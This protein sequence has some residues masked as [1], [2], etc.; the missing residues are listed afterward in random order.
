L[1]C[2]A[3][4]FFRRASARVFGIRTAREHRVFRTTIDCEGCGLVECLERGNECI[5][6]I[7]T[8]EVL[9]ACRKILARFQNGET[10]SLA[11]KANNKHLP[12]EAYSI[13]QRLHEGLAADRIYVFGSYARGQVGPDSDLDFLVVVPRSDVS[14]YDRAV[15]AYRLAG[16]VSVPKD[17]VVLTQTEWDKQIKAPSSLCSTVLREGILIDHEPRV[18]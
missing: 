13:A 16:E 5:N 7:T 1:D 2:D 17:I 12:A 14:S 3:S 9:G 4:P 15:E 8:D 6:R 10:V 11:V 18:A